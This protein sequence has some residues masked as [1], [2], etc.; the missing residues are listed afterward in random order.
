MAM[1]GAACTV[2][3][4]AKARAAS[5]PQNAARQ[6][7]CAGCKRWKVQRALERMRFTVRDWITARV[8]VAGRAGLGRQPCGFDPVETVK[9]VVAA[10]SR[11]L[12]LWRNCGI[13]PG[14]G[15]AVICAD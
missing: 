8:A 15:V 1:A 7:S 13:G 6:A 11:P 9:S 12:I 2:R 4:G 3:G 14:H 10:G 5:R